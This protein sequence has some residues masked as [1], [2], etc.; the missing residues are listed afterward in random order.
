MKIFFNKIRVFVGKHKKEI[1]FGVLVF[2]TTTTSF[3][4][5]YLLGRDSSR[6]PIIIQKVD[7]RR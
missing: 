4:L 5:G 7:A 3:A 2:L 6:A 1:V